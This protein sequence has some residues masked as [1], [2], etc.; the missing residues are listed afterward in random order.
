MNELEEI[1]ELEAEKAWLDK[2]TAELQKVLTEERRRRREIPHLIRALQEQAYGEL[3]DLPTHEQLPGEIRSK[4]C[5]RLCVGMPAVPKWNVDVPT[6]GR[7]KHRKRFDQLTLADLEQLV[8]Y[9]TTLAQRGI[10]RYEERQDNGQ[11]RENTARTAAKH[12]ALARRYRE[13]YYQQL[14]EGEFSEEKMPFSQVAARG[15]GLP[16]RCW[17]EKR[18]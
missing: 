1:A 4:L 15:F 5:S 8:L 11:P 10:R 2:H 3:A 16:H 9:H 18:R 17:P 12:I 14:G 6:V 7:K 13:W